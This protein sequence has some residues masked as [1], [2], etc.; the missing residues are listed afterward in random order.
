MVT[1][2]KGK[3]ER[4]PTGQWELAD[5]DL[6]A[7]LGLFLISWANIESTMEVGIGKLLGLDPMRAS[8]VTASL[9]FRSR[10]EILLALLNLDPTNN[11]AAI[12]HVKKAQQ[13]ADRNDIIHGV[14]GGS[15]SRIWF[16]RRRVDGRLKSKIERYS[17][18][19]LNTVAIECSQLATALYQSL[20][21][22]KEEYE[23]FF[24]DSHNRAN[25]VE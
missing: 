22:T 6:R 1:P 11:S 24:Q 16:N 15:K 10:S 5:N 18:I 8:I 13:I 20:G 12:E 23:K 2:N 21:L 4:A 25:N 19:R 17:S 3:Q 7:A 9:Q 14:V